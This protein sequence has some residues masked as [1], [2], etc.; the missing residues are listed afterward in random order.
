MLPFKSKNRSHE[1]LGEDS[2]V[3]IT[4]N[5][6]LPCTVAEIFLCIAARGS[7][8]IMVRVSVKSF[9]GRV[10]LAFSHAGTERD[11]IMT[12]QKSV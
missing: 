1:T 8:W 12:Q 6:D 4:A 5:T 9:C 11:I 2:P 10:A 7:Y 3:H